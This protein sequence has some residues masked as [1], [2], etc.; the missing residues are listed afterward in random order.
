MADKTRRRTGDAKLRPSQQ[1]PENIGSVAESS[2]ERESAR[3]VSRLK[4]LSLLHSA[5]RRTEF[6]P[7]MRAYISA[8]HTD[9]F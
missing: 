5:I 3:R 6:V 9:Q 1:S 7:E 8:M 4:R 2:A